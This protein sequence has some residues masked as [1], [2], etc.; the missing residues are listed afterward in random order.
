MHDE[1]PRYDESPSVLGRERNEG[2]GPQR[3]QIKNLKPALTQ[4]FLIIPR[5]LETQVTP[6]ISP[7][8][9]IPLE[10]ETRHELVPEIGGIFQAELAGGWGR[11][12]VGEAG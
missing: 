8:R 11:R 10:P 7:L 1:V 6:H 4:T 12:R 2:L 9:Y 3:R 5:Q